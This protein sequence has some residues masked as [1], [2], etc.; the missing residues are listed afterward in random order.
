M[1]SYKENNTLPPLVPVPFSFN[2]LNPESDQHQISP[3]NVWTLYKTEWSWELRTGSH[4]MN[5]L[6]ILTISPFYF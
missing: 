5:L 1:A 2:P 6:D 3:C 4:K